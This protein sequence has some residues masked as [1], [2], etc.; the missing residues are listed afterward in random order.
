MGLKAKFLVLR[1]IRTFMR[2][3]LLLTIVISSVNCFSQ[4]VVFSLNSGTGKSFIFESID[5]SVNV[6]YG[7]PL[8][9]QSEMTYFPKE[10]SWGLKLR[11]SSLKSTIYGD[12]W[13]TGTPLNGYINDFT[14]AL[15]LEK[16]FLEKNIPLV[17]I[18]AWDGR[19]SAYNLNKTI[20]TKKAIPIPAL[21]W[22]TF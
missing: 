8:L 14:T 20:F 16:K 19:T 10:S 1:L 11:I 4:K 22:A 18:L 21:I 13:M 3:I 2:T 5:K 7:L 15:L 17:S 6:K 9:L 12:N